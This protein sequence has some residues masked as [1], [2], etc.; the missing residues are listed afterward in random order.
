MELPETL[1]DLRQQGAEPLDDA[2][3]KRL[4]VGKSTWMK[5]TVT[6]GVFLVVW[7][8]S[9]QRLVTNVDGKIPQPSETG[10][11][12]RNGVIGSPSAYVVRD[13]RIVTTLGNAPF[14]MALY[15]AGDK[16]LAVR[17]NE[18][19]YANYEIVPA[20]RQLGTQIP[21]DHSQSEAV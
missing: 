16:Y 5:N 9:G 1:A 10:D 19:G 21:E 17:S 18:F 8:K 20:P 11:V 7:E 12:L 4:I 6:G 3:V 14:E 13:G 15:K 2:Q